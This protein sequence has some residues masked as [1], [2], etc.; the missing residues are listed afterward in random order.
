MYADFKVV[1]REDQSVGYDLTS[2]E[3]RQ[4]LS[5]RKEHYIGI[6]VG[7]RSARACVMN[8]LGDIIGVASHNIDLWQPHPGHY[9]QSLANVWQ[10]ICISV[11][12]VML[13]HKIDNSTVRGIGFAA[14]CSL[15]VMDSNFRSI[16]V[17]ASSAGDDD[18]NIIL[19][20]D[21]RASKETALINGIQHNVLRAIFH[22]EWYGK[23]GWQR[24][25]LHQIR[26]DELCEDN[27]RRLGG[28][29]G[30]NGAHYTAGDQCG[31]LCDKAAADMN[32]PS[33]IPRGSG[34]IDAYAGWIGTVGADISLGSE[35]N[36]AKVDPFAKASSSLA[37]V[38]GTSTCHLVLSKQP[39]FVDGVW[40]P[41]LDVI[42]PGYCMTEGGQSATGELLRHTIETHP[43]FLEAASVARTF[44][45][46]IYEYL[47]DHLRNMRVEQN[48]ACI[49]YL[50]RHLFFYGDLFGNRSPY[51]SSDMK[52]SVVGLSS[53]S[54]INALAVHYY[55]T[56]ESIALQTKQIVD[57]MNASGHR[58][59][60]I[61]MSGS[62]C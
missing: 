10:S 12:E 61:F 49:P 50:A 13:Q 14:T 29:N 3:T 59:R 8:E 51:A 19:W 41:Y 4:T 31:T 42:I 25:F 9:E 40:G 11:K 46:N 6:D 48:A 1:E 26:L 5:P 34:V 15:V 23:M 17:T 32:L 54:G 45:K 21:H 43:A 28:I 2:V 7:T 39:T 38:A 18:H 27:F 33:G 36:D 16:S 60:T 58:I 47:N 35:H 52:G 56:M 62:Q 20:L 37:A 55:V 53:D 24:D 22:L 30:V 57:H 44:G